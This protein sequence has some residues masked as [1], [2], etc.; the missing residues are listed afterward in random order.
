MDLT[1]RDI[2][3]TARHFQASVRTRQLPRQPTHRE[4]KKR[5]RGEEEREGKG[6]GK[7]EEKK[8]KK[9][10]SAEEEKLFRGTMGLIYDVRR[11]GL[12]LS[13]RS[14]FSDVQ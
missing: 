11:N 6:E 14:P 2:P 1:A 12:N 4:E 5:R 3:K 9:E 13:F 10:I 7:E 8:A